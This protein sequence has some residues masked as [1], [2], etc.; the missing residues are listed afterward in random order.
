MDA[1]LAIDFAAAEAFYGD[2][3]QSLLAALANP[4]V[5]CDLHLTTFVMRLFD[6]DQR[7]QPLTISFEQ[8]ASRPLGLCCSVS[9]AR[10]TAEW[11]ESLGL[12]TVKPTRDPNG[13]RGPNEY[14]LSWPGVLAILRRQPSP[15]H[16]WPPPV[17][18]GQ[19]PVATQQAGPDREGAVPGSATRVGCQDSAPSAP[20]MEP[21]VAVITRAPAS[22]D[23]LID[24]DLSPLHHPLPY[25][26]S[27]AP[28]GAKTLPAA[29][30][31]IEVAFRQT[32]ASARDSITRDV[33]VRKCAQII[34]DPDLHESVA[35]RLAD[36]VLV[37][38]VPLDG[39]MNILHDV[40][41]ARAAGRIRTS[42]GAYFTTAT[43]NLLRQY[44]VPWR[45]EH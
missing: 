2:R 3:R 41:R 45:K 10:S 17:A 8:L 4:A 44:S 26:G 33:F 30:E 35:G 36:A 9:K 29:D 25:H 12:I 16:S 18:T 11:A 27:M 40:Q 21:A 6:A 1:Q 7:E 38:K 5:K 13:M 19:G 37:G 23:P 43:K 24:K 31:L 32:Q 14:R 39:A 22:M 20:S 42:P 28:R 34:D 15:A